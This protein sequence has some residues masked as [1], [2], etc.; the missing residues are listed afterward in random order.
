[1]ADFPDHTDVLIVGGGIGGSV[2]AL[3]L[4]RRGRSVC[5]LEREAAPHRIVRP[6]GIWEATIKALEELGIGPKLC[7]EATLPIHS[8]EARQA[9][10]VLLSIGES[11]FAAAKTH[12]YSSDP[13]LTR[14]MLIDKALETGNVIV[15]RG[16][17][18]TDVIR[19]GNAIAGA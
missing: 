17:E 12:L 19:E 5:I 10:E 4:G 16:T 3:L 18:V 9:N 8:F 7:S 13:N 6:E 14:S 15:S 2:L 1:M 11:D